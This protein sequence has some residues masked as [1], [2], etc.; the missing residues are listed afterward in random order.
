MIW[1]NQ[2]VHLGCIHWT[3]DKEKGRAKT[4]SKNGI[5]KKMGWFGEGR[6]M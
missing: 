1:A 3:N 5:H 4:I 6:Y 2:F